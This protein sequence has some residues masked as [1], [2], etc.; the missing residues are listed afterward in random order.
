MSS[1]HSNLFLTFIRTL[2]VPASSRFQQHITLTQMSRST[3]QCPWD[4]SRKYARYSPH[5]RGDII[6]Q[7]DEGKSVADI[8]KRWKRGEWAITVEIARHY[9][10]WRDVRP[11]RTNRHHQQQPEAFKAVEQPMPFSEY[12]KFAKMQQNQGMN[13]ETNV[14]KSASRNRKFQGKQDVVSESAK[15]VTDHLKAL[16]Q[17]SFH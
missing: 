8:A 3:E 10:Y 5:E 6:S 12:S 11:N 7:Y 17:G 2:Q 9:N 14:K 13:S 4:C 1:K 15:E 16:L